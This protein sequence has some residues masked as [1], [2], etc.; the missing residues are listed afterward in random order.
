MLSTRIVTVALA[1]ALVAAPLA[2]EA[3]PAGKI[4]RLG[5]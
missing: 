5:H 3:Q 2:G 1:V 4:A